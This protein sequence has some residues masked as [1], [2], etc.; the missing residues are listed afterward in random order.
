MD[1]IYKLD[2][3]GMKHLKGAYCSMQRRDLI[4]RVFV[5]STFNDLMVE[6]NA[7][8]EQ[9]FPKLREYC[10]QRGARFQAIDLRWGVSGEAALDQQT[11][12]I[13]FQELKRCQ[14]VSPRPNFIVMLGERY[15]WRPL[16][17]QIEAN[18]FEMILSQVPDSH[19]KLLDTDSSVQA[20]LDG[21]LNIRIGWYRKDLNAVPALYVLQSRRIEFPKNAS[22]M[23]VERIK[24]EERQDWRRLEVQMHSLLSNAITKLNWY[25]NDPR[26]FK[27]EASATHQEIQAGALETED[28]QEHVFC[29]FREIEGL[30]TDARATIY[31]DIKGGVVD[32]EAEARLLALKT[33]IQERLPAAHVIKVRGKWNSGH[34]EYDIDAFCERVRSDLKNVIDR[35]IDAFKYQSRI[36]R[37]REAHLEFGEERCRHFVGRQAILQ[38]IQ[39]YVSS[40]NMNP[41]IIYG[42]SGFVLSHS[43]QIL[44]ESIIACKIRVTTLKLSGKF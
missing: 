17:P 23:D 36:N 34:P 5:S 10:Q 29:Y 8:Q 3:V 42:K 1:F 20:W 28:I 26:R 6:R 25:V 37:V 24:D 39:T 7:L 16:P 30:P 22:D 31:R 33:Q 27:Y 35:E 38:H 32:S 13:C 4:F 14:D 18:E 9:T 44:I 40:D 11:M 2:S 15:G 12:N 19:K 43:Y 41:L 21:Q